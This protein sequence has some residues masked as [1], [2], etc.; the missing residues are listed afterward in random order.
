MGGD[1]RHAEAGKRQRHELVADAHAASSTTEGATEAHQQGDGRAAARPVR[2]GAR[3]VNY[4]ETKRRG[5]RGPRKKCGMVV[6][7]DR[8]GD[9]GGRVALKRAIVVSD[10]TI[11]RIVGG[12]YEWRDG[13]YAARRRAVSDGGG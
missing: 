7:M 9:T 5:P 3:Q 1:P 8:R 6:Y 11:E 4:S 10:V 13:A 12:A 2:A